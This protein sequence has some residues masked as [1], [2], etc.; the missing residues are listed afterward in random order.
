MRFDVRFFFYSLNLE[1]RLNAQQY[2]DE[3]SYVL[4]QL[5]TVKYRRWILFRF[6]PNGEDFS[7]YDDYD[8]AFVSDLDER[9]CRDIVRKLA[10]KIDCDP[11]EIF[12]GAGT[13]TQSAKTRQPQLFWGDLS[14]YRLFK[15]DRP[16]S[17]QMQFE[18]LDAF[19]DLIYFFRGD[20]GTSV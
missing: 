14:C 15:Y 7:S 11:R 2:K 6:V 18:M 16:Q 19:Q 17:S 5:D 12:I 10:K 8:V 9:L 1:K 4:N 3:Y 20:N 13:Y